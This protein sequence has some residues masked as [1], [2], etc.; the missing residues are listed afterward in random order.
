MVGHSQSK[1]I[2]IFEMRRKS[3]NKKFKPKKMMRQSCI[4]ASAYHDHSK[5]LQT[6]PFRMKSWNAKK[7]DDV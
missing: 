6:H 5:L 2:Y 4:G 3:N 7:F 1:S